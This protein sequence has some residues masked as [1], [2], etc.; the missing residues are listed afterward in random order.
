MSAVA[1]VAPR[2]QADP[3]RP[4]Y[5]VTAPAQWINDPNGPIFHKGYYHLFYQHYPFSDAGGPKYWGHVRS[6]DLV[7]WEHLP[8]ALWPSTEKGESEIWSG[9][10]T[11]NGNGQPM[12]FYTSIA[13][14]KNAGDHAEQ[15]AA[16]GDDDLIT[17]QKHPANPILTEQLHGGVKVNDWRDPFIFHHEGRTFMVLGGNLNAGK[18]GEAVVNIYE[19]ENAALT[20]WKYR[21]ILFHHPDKEAA[22]AECPNFFQIGKQWVLFVSPYG[23]VQYFVGD[24]NAKTCRFEPKTR[25]EVDHAGTFYAPNTLLQSDGKRIVWGW[26]MGF[27]NGHGWNGCLSLPRVLSLSKEGKLLQKPAPQLTKLRGER[28]SWKTRRLDNR[29]E[30]LTLPKT[31]TW[32]LSAEIDLNT[33]KGFRLNF[34]SA[35][36][37]SPPIT[38]SFDGSQ[39]EAVGV[40]APFTGKKL[41]LRIFLDHSVMEVFVNDEVCI[42]RIVPVMDANAT[43]EVSAIGGEA[44]FKHLEM[45]PMK[46]I[47]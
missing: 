16:L 38:V 33:A 37:D 23:K 29:S 11:I 46:T 43:L 36:K 44:Q 18:G 6:R 47:W 39:F 21:G 8:I 4:I 12:I 5:H 35:A 14:G 26:I 41:H 42:T 45:W 15:W 1:A 19:A 7:K 9:C 17:W 30:T 22:S 27:P 20:Q 25:G 13:Q 32:E 10:A 28:L 3:A 2:A 34:K 40:K 31:N 24:F